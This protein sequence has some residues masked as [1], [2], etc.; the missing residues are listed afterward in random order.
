V[1]TCMMPKKYYFHR[2]NVISLPYNPHANRDPSSSSSSAGP[3]SDW[4]PSKVHAFPPV[5]LADPTALV[6]CETLSRCYH[7]CLAPKRECDAS[8]AACW[9]DNKAGAAAEGAD[10]QL[11]RM[12]SCKAFLDVQKEVCQCVHDEL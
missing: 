12:T 7:E 9:K 5:C 3:S 11:D 8:F 6:C 10:K 2:A 1:K 4:S